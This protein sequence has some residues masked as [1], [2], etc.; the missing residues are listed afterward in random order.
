MGSAVLASQPEEI[1][2]F[3]TEN[4]EGYTQPQLDALNA[5]LAERLAGV[6]AWSEE[7]IEIVKAFTD[8]VASR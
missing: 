7:S 8:E 3:T 4:T 2:M 6:E 5:E 1:D